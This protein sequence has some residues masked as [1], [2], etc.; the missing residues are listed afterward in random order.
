MD[1]AMFVKIHQPLEKP[2]T[3]KGRGVA[4][5]THLEN[6]INE[7]ANLPSACEWGVVDGT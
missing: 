7:I 4:G 5:R 3:W 1:N 6:L 2:S